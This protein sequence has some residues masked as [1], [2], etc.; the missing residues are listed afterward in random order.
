MSLIEH[1]SLTGL[2]LIFIPSRGTKIAF[3]LKYLREIYFSALVISMVEYV[4]I[5]DLT[6]CFSI[7]MTFWLVLCIAT[8]LPNTFG[9]HIFDMI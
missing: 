5:D 7:I 1:I 6:F 4:H 3:D 8:V 9:L 2:Y